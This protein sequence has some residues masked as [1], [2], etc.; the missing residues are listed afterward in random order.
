MIAAKQTKMDIQKKVKLRT[1]LQINTLKNSLE[2]VES[3]EV[4][5]T[6]NCCGKQAF[7]TE[8]SALSAIM[9]IRMNSNR[10]HRAYQCPTGKWHLTSTSLKRYNMLKQFFK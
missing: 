2:V 4:Y 7:D 3:D 8:Q 6:G 9:N 1:L 10:P 5:A